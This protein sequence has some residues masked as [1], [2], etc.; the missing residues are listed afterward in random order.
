MGSFTVIKNGVPNRN[1]NG[2]VLTLPGHNIPLS[3]SNC[4]ERIFHLFTDLKWYTVK[5]LCCYQGELY[6]SVASVD[7]RYII[8]RVGTRAS[9]IIIKPLTFFSFRSPK[10][11]NN[12]SARTDRPTSS[13]Y[14][15]ERY[16]HLL[17]LF[18]WSGSR[19][20]VHQY[21]AVSGVMSSLP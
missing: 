15:F 1:T 12:S 2:L 16:T 7:R 9:E 3:F 5:S 13:A 10:W 6:R 20:A 21:V 8:N 14:C 17:T 19:S 11:G 18:K 4:Q